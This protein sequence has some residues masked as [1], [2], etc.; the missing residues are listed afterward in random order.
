MRH[1]VAGRML[2]VTSTHRGAMFRNMA[3]AS[4]KHEQ[5]TIQ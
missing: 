4:I 2:G 1:G 5:I 3:V